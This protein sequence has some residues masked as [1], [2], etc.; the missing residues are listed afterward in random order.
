MAVAISEQIL[1][2]VRQRLVGIK[3]ANGYELT[4]SEVIRPTRLGGFRPKHLQL[5]VTLGGIDRNDALSVPGNPPATAHE[6]TVDIA[7]LLM[8]TEQSGDKIDAL[9]ATFA[10]DVIKAVATPQASWHNWDGLAIDTL[11]GSVADETTEESSG[12][13]LPLT[14]TFRTTENNPYQ[15]RS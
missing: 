8:P 14:I 4:V 6:M 3:V 5:V 13:S 7:G 11:I 9:R 10:A 1:D 2:K 12:F 15:G